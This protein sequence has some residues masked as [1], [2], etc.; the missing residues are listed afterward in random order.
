MQTRYVVAGLAVLSALVYLSIQ[1]VP[2]A[3]PTLTATQTPIEARGNAVPENSAASAV[4]S[5]TVASPPQTQTTA[6]VAAVPATVRPPSPPQRKIEPIHVGELHR[7][8]LEKFKAFTGG[9]DEITPRHDALA[10]E[11]RDPQWSYDMEEKLNQFLVSRGAELGIEAPV[12]ACRATGCEI[13]LITYKRPPSFDQL[14]GALGKEPWFNLTTTQQARVP[15]ASDAVVAWLFF[16]R[17]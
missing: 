13:Q 1:H 7:Q 3:Q 11:P 17:P 12:I 16:K 10:A 4:A 15:V 6:T 9:R 5:S 14:I 2:N 8:A